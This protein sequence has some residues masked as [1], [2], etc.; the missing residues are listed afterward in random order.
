MKKAFVILTLALGSLTMSAQ[1]FGSS[2]YDEDFK[3]HEFSP[4]LGIGGVLGDGTEKGFALELGLKYAYRFHPN[5]AWDAVK[6]SAI[7]MPE[8]FT[9]SMQIQ[10][11]S[12]FR[13]ITPVLFGNST[14]YAN[15]GAGYGYYTDL[16]T[17]GFAWEVGAGV[18]INQRF[19]V[20]IVYNST[21]IS[22]E[23]IEDP[24]HGYEFA[25]P[26]SNPGFIGARFAYTF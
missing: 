11:L 7:T 5:I 14:L 20:G 4:M 23:T 26:S 12:G 9:E 17:G 2:S 24:Y 19:S 1:G 22:G 21:H 3:K 15:F 18:C 10:A 16:E 6:V 25:A 13:G 8:H